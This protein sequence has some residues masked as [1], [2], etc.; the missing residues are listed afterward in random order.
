[1]RRP[2]S[3]KTCGFLRETAFISSTE[4]WFASGNTQL[5]KRIINTE[6]SVA[7]SSTGRI[8][9]K[10]ETPA[11]LTAVISWSPD[12]RPNAMRHA[13]STAIGIDSES[14]HARFSTNISRTVEAGNPLDS[15]LS[16]IFTRKSTTNKNVMPK[17]AAINGA[18]SSFN[19]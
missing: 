6:R 11:A 12:M 1:M 4:R 16:R 19:T 8:K 15:T 13:T 18:I 17:R 10:G 14:I 3:I 5:L 2:A 7:T 9:L